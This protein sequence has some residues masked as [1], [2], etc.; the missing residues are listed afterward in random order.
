MMEF[1]D[2]LPASVPRMAYDVTTFLAWAGDRHMAERKKT[3]I[4]VYPMLAIMSAAMFYIW[5]SAKSHYATATLKNVKR[6]R[7]PGK[8]AKW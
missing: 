8:E 5:R 7:P 1:E 2:G 6:I 4:T 3:A